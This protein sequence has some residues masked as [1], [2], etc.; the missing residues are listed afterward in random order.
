V[1][2]TTAH[3]AVFLLICFAVFLVLAIV[4]GRVLEK[5][6]QSLRGWLG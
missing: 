5:V 1:I 3:M 4:G 2:E 6:G